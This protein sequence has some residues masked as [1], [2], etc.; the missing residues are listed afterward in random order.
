MKQQHYIFDLFKTLID[1]SGY[2]EIVQ[3]LFPQIPSNHIREYLR[4]HSFNSSDDAI[5]AIGQRYGIKINEEKRN[6][7][8]STLEQW[9]AKSKLF[10]GVEETL[11]V[12]KIRGSKLG[13]ISNNNKL[14]E[15]AFSD[16]NLE[17]Y[18]DAVVFSHEVGYQKPQEEIYNICLKKMGVDPLQTTMIGDTLRADVEKPLEL[19]ME[20]ILFDPCEKYDYP[21][22]ISRIDELQ[23]I[24]KISTSTQRIYYQYK[25]I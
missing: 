4:V 21:N 5:T 7:V 25:I 18:F 2:P 11:G 10:P 15:S 20:A 24:L 19:G 8:H 22:R 14:I 13:L 9:L 16:M 17:K 12:L 1:N 23:D 6:E 3:E